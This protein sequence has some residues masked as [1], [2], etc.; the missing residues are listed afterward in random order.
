MANL[1]L[2]KLSK[3]DWEIVRNDLH[4]ELETNYCGGSISI[5][6]ELADT[7][8]NQFDSDFYCVKQ[9]QRIIK[10]IDKAIEATIFLG[11]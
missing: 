5:P 6:T 4:R 10:E 11:V 1:I 9:Y 8:T 7:P 3:K 2:V